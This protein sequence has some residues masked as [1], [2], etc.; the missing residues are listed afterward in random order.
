MFGWDGDQ[1]D[2]SDLLKPDRGDKNVNIEE[3]VYY[4]R[5]R[6]GW[7]NADF[8]VGGTIDGLKRF[9]AAGYPVVIEK[10]FVLD[11]ND[12][13]GGWAGHYLLLTGYDDAAAEFIVQDS[14]KGPDR[15]VGYAELDAA[16]EAFNRV[17]VYIYPPEEQ[18]AIDRLLGPDADADRNRERALET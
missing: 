2:V 5:N 18:A 15:R 6:A 9:L 14:N 11:E 1:F 10:G 13:G 17:F 8:R 3:L 16:W 4:V 12:G 7:L